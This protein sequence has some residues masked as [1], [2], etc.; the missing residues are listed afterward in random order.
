[1]SKNK[2]PRP[3]WLCPKCGMKWVNC[4][5]KCI[6]CKMYGEAQNESAGKILRRAEAEDYEREAGRTDEG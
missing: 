4:D 5:P 3:V 2:K 6:V 1:M